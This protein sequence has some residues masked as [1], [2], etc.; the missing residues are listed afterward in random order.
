MSID[1]TDGDVFGIPKSPGTY[2]IDISVTNQILTESAPLTLTV[3]D[4]TAGPPGLYAEVSAKVGVPFSYNSQLNGQAGT[5]KATN[6]PPGLTI[7]GS[8]GLITGTPGTLGVYVVRITATSTS[9]AVSKQVA[10][11]VLAS[12]PSASLVSTQPTV[13]LGSGGAG[14]FTLSL[15]T[16]A[17][18]DQ[19]VYY[20]V[21]GSARNGLDY[22]FL[23]GQAKIKAGNSSKTI[24]I[25][26]LG[27]LGGAS[28]RTVKLSLTA[29]LG[30][31]A[32]GGKP[33]KVTIL[34]P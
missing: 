32:D 8:S 5:Y 9:G 11:D 31:E 4:P 24:R 27:N 30:Y 17:T 21:A 6:L 12:L 7:A 34:A 25:I 2:L 22:V 1:P 16:P 23:K 18:V 33:A 14:A 28:K 3:E 13:T 29:G 15:S 20:N 26:P 10:V 19:F